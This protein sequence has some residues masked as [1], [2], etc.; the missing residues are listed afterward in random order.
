MS[1]VFLI[2]LTMQWGML[3]NTVTEILVH[4]P[5]IHPSQYI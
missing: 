1:K 3:K 2:N 5:C 4:I